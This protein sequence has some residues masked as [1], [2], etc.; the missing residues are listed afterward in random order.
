[1]A[2]K[3]TLIS[4]ILR[5]MAIKVGVSQGYAVD[6][7]GR[8]S[9]GARGVLKS[10]KRVAKKYGGRSLAAK[11]RRILLGTGALGGYTLGR[12]RRR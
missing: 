7:A 8:L 4:N 12:R 5:K 9:K 1:M 6:V 2:S 11:K 3:Y 10:G